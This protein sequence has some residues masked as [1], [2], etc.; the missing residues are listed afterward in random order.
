MAQFIV[1]LW[2][3]NQAEEAAQYYTSIFPNSKIT[4]ITR[5]TEVGPGPAG[6]VMTV[7]LELDGN[8][9]TLINGGADVPWT[10]NESVSIEVPCQTQ[11]EIDRYWDALLAD[12]GQASQC[13]WL[14]DRYGVSWQIVPAGMEE[15]FAGDDPERVNRAMTA[16]LSMVKL[17]IAALQNA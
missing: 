17:D 2:F 13:G 10:F 7:S 3:D 8:K 9:F 1:N 12:G 16:M 14:K 6:E 4:G 5:Y 15:L 11:A